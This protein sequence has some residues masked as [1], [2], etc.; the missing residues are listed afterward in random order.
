MT[1][2]TNNGSDVAHI[3]SSI[4]NIHRDIGWDSNDEKI[5][6]SALI[7]AGTWEEILTVF[8]EAIAVYHD[9]DTDSCHAR[10]D[11]V[12]KMVL[13]WHS[14]IGDLHAQDEPLVDDLPELFRTCKQYGLKVAVCTSDNRSSTNLALSRWGVNALV[15]V[16]FPT[17]M[18]MPCIS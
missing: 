11:N 9:L 3:E 17:M 10:I 8:A 16:S 1:A 14:S 18:Y 6:P 15:D 5:L 4:A 13:E 7:A 12:Q 2:T